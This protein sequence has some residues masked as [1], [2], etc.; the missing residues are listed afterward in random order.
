MKCHRVVNPFPHATD[1]EMSYRVVN[2]FPH[3]TDY[4]MSY[5]VVNPFPHATDY[6]MSYR[7]NAYPFPHVEASAADEFRHYCVKK[8]KYSR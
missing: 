1:Y 8:R 2:P 7:V 5:R 3:A 4:E 6:E